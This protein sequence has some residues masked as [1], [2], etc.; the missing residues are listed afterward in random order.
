MK[1][2][3]DFVP[4]PDAELLVWLIPHLTDI[5]LM[6]DATLPNMTPQERAAYKAEVQELIDLLKQ[7]DAVKHMLTSVVELKNI[8][9][10]KVIRMIRNVA[11]CAKRSATPAPNIVGRMQ[12]VCKPV[13][14]DKTV[15]A[16]DITAAVY[17]EFVEV[18]FNK[19]LL[20]P[21][22]LYCRRGGSEEWEYIDKV[23]R[24][25]YKDERPLKVPGQPEWR[26][27]KAVYA[28]D[29]GTIGQFSNIV[30]VVFGG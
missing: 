3:K 23:F 9:R 18:A 26:E 7:V 8:K 22:D 10:K 28:E 17:P 25:P 24:S 5:D 12:L 15:V 21:V 19:K 14:V 1:K 27:Y 13:E 4:R 20:T 6:A 29:Q 16:P 2:Y 11:T 30:R